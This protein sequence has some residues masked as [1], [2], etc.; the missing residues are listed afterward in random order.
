MKKAKIKGITHT[1][2]VIWFRL[3]PC[4]E[5]V[6]I[7]NKL[8]VDLDKEFHEGMLKSEQ[9][10]VYSKFIPARYSHEDGTGKI[11]AISI[12]HKDLIDFIVLK[13]HPFYEKVKK[14]I[15]NNFVFLE[16]K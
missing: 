3:E 7:I 6:Y 11:Y 14:I 13:N 1:D 4:K 5:S 16:S 15:M 12:L 9:K 2:N 8:A 10:I